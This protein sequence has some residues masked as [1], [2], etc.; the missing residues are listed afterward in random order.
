VKDKAVA[1]RVWARARNDAGELEVQA[2]EL[3]VRAERRTGD[4]LPEK[5]E[6][7]RGRAWR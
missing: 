1:V 4:L 7:G 3:R 6:P 2:G 5:G